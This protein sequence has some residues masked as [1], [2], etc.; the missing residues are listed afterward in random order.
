MRFFLNTNFVL[1]HGASLKIPNLIK[2]YVG[3]FS[4]PALIYDEILEGQL[5]FNTALD[6]LK[7]S[8]PKIHI[9]VNDKKGE[10][11]YQ[12]LNLLSAQKLMAEI[13]WMQMY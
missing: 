6:N 7:K 11:T 12:Y 4:K 9:R 8:F 3:S 10:P 2:E 13:Q 1:E 5:Y